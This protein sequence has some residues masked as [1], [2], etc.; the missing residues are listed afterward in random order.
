MKAIRL[1]KNYLHLISRYNVN[2][3]SF[4]KFQG[5][6]DT[7]SSAD[8]CRC[9]AAD[10]LNRKSYGFEIKRDFFKLADMW[11]NENKEKKKELKELGYAKTEIS[12]HNPILF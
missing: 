3:R 1:N 5:L 7:E 8:N 9:P 11:I 2:S 10:N 4:S 12:K 6:S